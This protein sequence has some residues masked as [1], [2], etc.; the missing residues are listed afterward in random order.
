MRGESFHVAKEGKRYVVFDD[1]QILPVYRKH[2]EFPS[3]VVR[4]FAEQAGDV[5]TYVRSYNMSYNIGQIIQ[6]S[7]LWGSLRTLRLD[8]GGER[9]K[10]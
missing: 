4:P 9:N 8:I 10:P 3:N 6:V 2:L 5:D 7:A 1:V